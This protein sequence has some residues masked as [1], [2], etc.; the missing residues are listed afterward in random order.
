MPD[1]GGIRKTRWGLAALAVALCSL[2]AVGLLGRTRFLR[3]LELKA[4]DLQFLARGRLPTSDII[5]L[6]IDQKSLDEL[7]EPLMFWHPYYAEAIR[8]AA[9]AG[10]RVLGLDVF[11]AIPV[12]QW[13]PDNDRL[14]AEA[15]VETAPAMPVICG[16]A[17]G[18]VNMQRQ[19][20]IPL[21]LFASASGLTASLHL[22]VDPDDF[23][24]R[25]Q[26]LEQGEGPME[27]R[28]RSFALAI[29]EKFRGQ[30]AR[31]E[32]GRLYL[33]NTW[34]PTDA[35]GSMAIN[36]AGPA[37]VFPRVSFADF[38]QAARAGD[39]QKLRGW[40]SGKIVLVGLDSISGQDRH[41]TPFYTLE[42]GARANT[43][44]FEI[45][46]SAIETIL[47][48]DFLTPPRPWVSEMLLF[49][50]AIGSAGAACYFRL[51]RAGLALAAMAVVILLAAHVSFRAG[52]VL[53]A[54]RML[55]A[56]TVAAVAALVYHTES[57]RA[58]LARA[59]SIFVGKRAAQTLEESEGISVAAGVRQ[60]VT[61]LFSDIR[62]FTAFCE[63]KEPAVVVEQLNR[64]LTGMVEII[65][66][67]GGEVNKFIGDG[68]LA[69][70]SDQDSGAVPGDHARRAV[71][72]GIQM[73]QAP[74]VFHTGVGIHSGEVVA[75]NV[76]SFDKLE[77]TVL[78]DAV[79]LA[80]RLE[81][82]NK[83]FS[84]QLLLSEQTSQR[85]DGS[86]PVF[87]LGE[88]TVRGRTQAL[89]VFTP[90]VLVSPRAVRS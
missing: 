54:V 25:Q 31:I 67:H 11:F 80:S 61:I 47:G 58:F 83:E 3:L 32:G 14:L 12:S 17:P 51:R 65:L 85:L 23:V 66:R 20:P 15:V 52:V 18:A 69:I 22:E 50:A 59:F 81:G 55:L 70:F 72:C 27:T 8:A 42:P 76:G 26:L 44:G 75:G 46:A 84:T 19:R 37:G 7:P 6:A 16:F 35:A 28:T 78:G 79:N 45:H 49:L 86:I 30:Q 43:A 40:V 77:Y 21:Y 57:K 53:P 68:I 41:A 62:G 36:Y 13:A 73:V 4:Y 82:M 88:V 33:G 2:A 9:G 71:A 74:G 29:A 5:L 64:Y 90:A 63:A 1:A 34:I 48:R 24:R 89:H 60:Q 56:L 38:I 87:N 10:A 39:R